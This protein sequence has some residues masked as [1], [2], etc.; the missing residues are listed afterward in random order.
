MTERERAWDPGT[1]CTSRN[2]SRS[3][4]TVKFVKVPEDGP[5]LCRKMIAFVDVTMCEEMAGHLLGPQMT[6]AGA[7]TCSHGHLSAVSTENPFSS[8]V[9][10]NLTIR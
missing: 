4:S 2:I 5:N 6:P 7:L 1:L 8:P 10:Y 9:S 3:L